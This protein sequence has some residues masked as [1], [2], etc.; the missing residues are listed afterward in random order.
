VLF[1]SLVANNLRLLNPTGTTISE[2]GDIKISTNS[3]T[4]TLEEKDTGNNQWKV[5]VNSDEF[6]IRHN[7]VTP[8]QLTISAADRVT[9]NKGFT[10]NLGA[11]I[12]GGITINNGCTV[13]NG[14]TVN[15]GSTVNGVGTFNNGITVLNGASI[16]GG[17]TSDSFNSTS[18]IRYKTNITPLNDAINLVLSLSGVRYDWKE[19]GRADIGLIAEEVN[20]VV[21]E[22]VLKTDDEPAAIDY[23]KLTAVLIEAVKELHKLIVK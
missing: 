23:G 16:T 4:I 8:Y 18:S 13:N 1:R 10:V 5:M 11:I 3:P 17:T 20:K 14:L 22:V 6:S 7:N 15:N 2:F 9:I 21:P 19:T 12:N